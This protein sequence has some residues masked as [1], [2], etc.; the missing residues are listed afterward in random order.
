[1]NFWF[2]CVCSWC[3][4]SLDRLQRTTCLVLPASDLPMTWHRPVVPAQ[5]VWLPVVLFLFSRPVRYRHHQSQSGA[6]AVASGPRP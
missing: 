4:A 3:T 5:L 6:A 2:V 1:M